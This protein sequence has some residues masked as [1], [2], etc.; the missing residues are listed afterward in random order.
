MMKLN[1]R[2]IP[3]PP[4]DLGSQKQEH[5]DIVDDHFWEL[6]N[7]V[8]D[9]TELPTAVLF[10]LYSAVRYVAAAEIPGDIIE[11]GVHM[12]GSIMM[13]ELAL[14]EVEKS[15][16]RKIFAL[17]TFTGFVRRTE[18]LDVDLRSRA[19]VC[20]PEEGADYTQGA[21]ENMKS[22]A[23]NGL[24]V[25]KGCVLTTIPTLDIE[26]IALL[27]LDTDTYDT[28]KFELEQLYDRVVVGGVVIVDDYG[29]TVGCKKAVDD[30]VA[31]RKIL[32]QRINPNVRSWIKAAL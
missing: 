26:K 14:L 27:R 10:N 22:I 4:L 18:G 20:H 30:F 9:Y 21:I 23:F 19:D 6:V 17:D 28:T 24:H 25:V 3:K 32:L 1:D 8:H 2:G 29:Y 31:S 11:C 15:T 16:S 12:G 13:M 5:P 7:R